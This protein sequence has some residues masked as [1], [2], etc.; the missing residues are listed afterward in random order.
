MPPTLLILGCGGFIGSHLV[1]RI[2]SATS[3][4]VIG[5]DVQNGRIARFLDNPKFTYV[6]LDVYDS[7]AVRTL[8][9]K[10]DIVLSLVALC[11]PSLYTTV[12][13]RVI[14]VNFLRPYELVQMCADMGKRLVHFSTCEVYGRTIAG[15]D[16]QQS[17]DPARYVLNEDTTPLIMGPISAQRWS[18]ASA[19]QLLERVIYAFGQEKDLDYTVI[20]PFNFIGPRMDFIPGVDGE[21]VP[22]VLACFMDA[23]LFHKPLML[24]DGGLNRRSFTY[25]DDAVDAIMAII[26][27]P[28]QARKQIF[29]IGNP[30]NEVSIAQL[31]SMMV[32]IYK[33][34]R[35]EFAECEFEIKAVSSRKFYGDG[36]EDSDRRVPDMAKVRTLL[37]W[38]PKVDLETALHKTIADYIAHYAALAECRKAG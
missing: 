34:L 25:I 36:Y 10:A 26:S 28:E 35:P 8:V 11:N 9:G 32:R 33:E 24:V 22:R 21:G 6:N 3:W 31:A 20:R 30:A 14:E 23:L 16:E 29:N 5:V 12:P 18:Y 19:K 2:L 15:F 7:A 37:S 38:E 4:K 17:D 27:R 13:L 1:D